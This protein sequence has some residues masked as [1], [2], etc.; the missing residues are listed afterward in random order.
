MEIP[1]TGF[2][3]SN[4]SGN[5]HTHGL[6][7]TSWDGRAVHL[8]QFAGVT[9]INDGHHHQYAGVTES[10]PTGVQHIHG[11]NTVTSFDNGHTHII[12]GRT[13]PDIPLQGGG[14]YHYFEGFTTINGIH[15]HTHNYNGTT[16]N[17][18]NLS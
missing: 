18:V 5:Q 15:P 6:Y 10:A 12:Q 7:I 16:G 3:I 13:G 4:D 14:H 9:S 8:H 17:E 2:I 1:I 11:Y